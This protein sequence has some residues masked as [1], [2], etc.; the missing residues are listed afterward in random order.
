MEESGRQRG[1]EGVMTEVGIHSHELREVGSLE[2]P[3][4]TRNTFSPR[5]SERTKLC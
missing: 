1:R 3:E 5:A 2:K 4:E